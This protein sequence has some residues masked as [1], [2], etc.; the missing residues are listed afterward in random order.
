MKLVTEP[1]FYDTQPTGEVHDVEYRDPT[2]VE[3]IESEIVNGQIDNLS[4][5]IALW[6]RT[7]MYRRHVREALA[8]HVE[9]VSVLFNKIRRVSQETVKRT[10]AVEKRQGEVEAKF[11]KVVA[12][13]TSASEIILARDSDTFGS[14]TT[15]DGRLEYLEALL[16]KYVPIGF[17]FELTHNLAVNPNVAITYYENAFDAEEHGFGSAPLM[18]GGSAIKTV[19]FDLVYLDS[20]KIRL[21]LPMDYKMA[22][23]PMPSPNYPNVYY[24]REKEKVLRIELT[25]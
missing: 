16:N 25:E 19:P 6:I 23:L 14:F 13:A 21:S 17:G 7:K 4:K 15:L 8:R 11:D 10:E 5:N 12:N 1:K 20:N 24:I 3:E 22:T 9:W 18:F 2:D